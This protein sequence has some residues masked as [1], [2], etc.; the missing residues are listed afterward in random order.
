MTAQKKYRSPQIRLVSELSDFEK[1]R[2]R[3]YA[4]KFVDLYKV[5]KGSANDYLESLGINMGETDYLRH[6]IEARLDPDDI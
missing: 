1:Y 2:Y 6:F 4:A 3:K 5:D